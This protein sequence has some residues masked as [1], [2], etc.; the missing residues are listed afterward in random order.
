MDSPKILQNPW[1]RAAVGTSGLSLFLA[2]A[3][4]QAR[5]ESSQYIVDGLALGDPVA[6]RSSA[7]Q[8]YRCGPSE[9]F[10][11]FVWCQRRRTEN[12]KF[13]KI[14]TITSILHSSAG[15]TEY[16][17]RYIEP[18]VF[19]PGDVAHEIKR[20]SQL[21]GSDPH[22]LQSSRSL[23]NIHAV[24][25]YWG[26][27]TLEPLDAR[28][29]AQIAAGRGVQKGMLFDFL[30]NYGQ[31]AN[32]HLPI[33]HLG[34]G[35]GYVWGAHFDENGLGALRMTAIDA[36]QFEGPSLVARG[37]ESSPPP[38]EGRSVA[39]APASRPAPPPESEGKLSSG[40]GFFVSNDGYIVTNNHVIEDCSAIR[41]FMD[42]TAP[43]EARTIARDTTNDLA[44]LATT[45][46]PPAIAA[47]RLGVRLGESVAAF[48]FPHADILASSG[49]FTQGNVTALAGIGDD[50]RY[51]Q[52]S[53]PVQAGNSGGPLLDQNGNLV[54]VVTSKLNAIKIAEASGDLPENVNFALKSSVV[55]NFLE[56]NRIKYASGSATL[57]LKS[58]DLADEAKS[59]S[60]FIL[61]K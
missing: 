23:A 49:N 11:T 61:C 4:I 19:R 41:V 54:G 31:S 8:E 29:I 38:V 15:T 2:G 12:G 58:E 47:P 35:P 13:G 32:A 30:G 51:L 33:F 18:A 53:A 24:I 25:A 21:F 55:A 39:P 7:Y 56:T 59:M 45:L 17:S 9:Q 43:A 44:L 57:S 20:L 36:A 60:V 26:D 52:I 1:R 27:V 50:S 14:S 28:S 16:I 42:K 46:K 48:G 34:G 22:V 5:A 10:A 37:E 6:P 40:S 3:I